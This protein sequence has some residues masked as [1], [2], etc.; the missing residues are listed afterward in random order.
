VSLARALYARSTRLLL[1]DDPL[2]AVD[3]HVGEHL[4]SKAIAGD[5][6]QGTTR[7]LVTHHVHFLPRC[8][9]VIVMDH[10]RIRHQGTYSELIA[11]GV[12][13]AGAVDVSK[14]EPPEKPKESEKEPTL[15]EAIEDKKEPSVREDEVEAIKKQVELKEKGENLVKEEEREE[16][17]VAGSAYVHYAKSGGWVQF[18]LAI[19]TQGI[20]RGCEI[21]ASF[22][23]AHWAEEA[24]A[25]EFSGSP[26]TDGETGFYLGIYGLFG[27]LGVCGLT[28]RALVLAYHRLGASRKLHDDLAKS[29]L[30]APVSF[31]DVTPTGRI[32]N[33]FAADMDKIDLQLTQSLGQLFT[34]IFSVLGA[35]GA[36]SAATRGTFLAPL[37]PMAYLYYL[38]QKWFRKTSTELQRVNSI[39]NSPIF[40]DFSQALSG[41]STIRAYGEEKRF[42]SNMKNSFNNQNA[43]YILVQLTNMWLGL[44]LDVLGGIIVAFIGGVAVGTSSK[45]FIPAG[46]LGLALSYGIEVTNYLKHGVRMIATLEAEMNSVERVLFYSNKIESEAPEDVP[47]KDPDTGSWPSSGEIEIQHASMRYR[48]GPLVLKDLTLTVKGG[49]RIGVVGRTGKSTTALLLPWKS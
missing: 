6:A 13:F 25:A 31:F 38:I 21:G 10:G 29:I 42:F 46:W 11:Q 34:T 5:F 14:A 36:I 45:G 30:R 20:G 3:A 9:H 27:F 35:L 41:T 15:E 48:D 22:W 23:L 33:R 7:I 8:D 40:A 17:Q 32:L 43:S 2:S 4:F 47:D 16:G 1:L 19:L 49:E 44:R 12:D 24:L 39:A 26:H 28:V 37:V 18:L